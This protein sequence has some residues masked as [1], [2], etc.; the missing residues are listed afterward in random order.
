MREIVLDTETTGLDPN[1]GHRLVEVGC[2]EL[3]N[4]IPTGATFHAYLNPD[5]DMPAEAFAGA[6]DDVLKKNLETIVGFIG[7]KARG[8]VLQDFIKQRPSEATYFNGLVAGKGRAAGVPTP[9]N[10]AIMVLVNRIERGELTAQI[11]NL[12]LVNRS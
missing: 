10:D 7:K 12:E 6:T 8:V 11:G 9:V 4:R 5:R 2:V 1:Q 3:L